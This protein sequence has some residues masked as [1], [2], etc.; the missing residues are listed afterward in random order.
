M[1]QSLTG[2]PV[3]LVTGAGQGIGRSIALAFAMAG[4]RVAVTGR[5][6]PK[7]EHVAG[8]CGGDAAAITLDVSAESSCQRAVSECLDRLGPVDVLVNSA[9]I[10]KSAKFTATDTGLWRQIM[11]VDVDGPF[12]LTRAV[13]PAMLE[14]DHGTVISIGSVASRVG[15]PYVAA[16]TAAKHALLGL[17]RALSAEYAR[18]GITFN[19]VCPHYTDTPLA[20]ETVRNIVARTGRGEEEALAHL[21]S[22]QGRLIDPA[23]VAALCLFLAS[24]AGR[25]ITGQAINIDGGTHQG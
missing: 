6:R 19:C 11:T 7:I 13:L 25:S 2:K 10:A 24:P 16:Y 20:A 4:A 17:T 12:W 8:E 5:T 1:H 15:L 23:D 9:G 18:T 14:R 22:P 21:L 3:V